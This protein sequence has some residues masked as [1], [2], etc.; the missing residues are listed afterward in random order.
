MDKLLKSRNRIDQIDTQIM[1]LLDERYSLSIEIGNIKKESNAPVLDS[2][3]E[4]II[5][6]KTSQLSH[7]LAIKNVYKSIMKESKNLQRK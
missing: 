5:L 3:R 7:S 6:D 4:Q 2:N 1:E